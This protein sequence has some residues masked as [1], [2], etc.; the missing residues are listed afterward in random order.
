MRDLEEGIFGPTGYFTD[1][2]KNA[3]Y[4]Q[5]ITGTRLTRAT[6]PTAPAPDLQKHYS[7]CFA[8]LESYTLDFA[9]VALPPE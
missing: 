8:E 2:V 6:Q 1:L 7:A 5:P 4:H 3:P 9:E